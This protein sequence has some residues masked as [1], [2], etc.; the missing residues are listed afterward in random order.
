MQLEHLCDLVAYLKGRIEGGHG[1]LENHGDPVATDVSDIRVTQPDHIPAVEKNSA[2]NDFAG[3]I[4]D[5]S[6]DRQC[7]DA[8]SAPGLPDQAQ[9]FTAFNFQIH[10]VDRFYDPTV[11]GKGGSEIFY[12]EQRLVFHYLSI[13]LDVAI[14]PGR[15]PTIDRCISSDQDIDLV[16]LSEWLRLSGVK[17]HTFSY[18]KSCN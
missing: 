5:Q 9:R 10:A 2:V 8:L 1:L 16:S 18:K 7:G 13:F 15:Q 14:T 17:Y 11:G 12:P 6:H 4:R 3:G